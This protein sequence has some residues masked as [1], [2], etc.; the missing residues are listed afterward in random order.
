METVKFSI[1]EANRKFEQESKFNDKGKLI[2]DPAL[3]QAY[4]KKY[5]Y[6]TYDGNHYLWDGKKFVCNTEE[7]IKKVYFNRLN[8]NISRWYFKTNTKLYHV[9]NDVNK[10]LLLDDSINLCPGFK[11]KVPKKFNSFSK[12]TREAVELFLSY[13]KEVLADNDDTS[14]IYIMKWTANMCRG[15]K[16][17]TCLYFKSPEG[18]GKSTFTDFLIEFVLGPLIT[19]VLNNADVLIT[20][21]NSCLLGMLLVIFEELPTFNDAQW[22]VSSGKLKHMITGK[23][24][25]FRDLYIKQFISDNS[26]NYVLNTNVDALK[27]SNGRRIYICKVSTKRQGDH[28]YFQKLHEVCFNA[29]VGEAFFSYLFEL[30][31]E[32]FEAQKDMPESDKK[33]D[34]IVKLLPNTYEFLKMTYIKN[35]R[36]L[37]GKLSDVYDEYKE[38][39][40]LNELKHVL[41]KIDFNSRLKE[42]GI[43][44]YLSKGINKFKISYEELC[45]ICKKNNWIHQLDEIFMG[46]VETKENEPIKIDKSIQLECENKKLK[47]ELDELKQQM[48]LLNKIPTK[49]ECLLKEPEIVKV[50]EKPPKKKTKKTKEDKIIKKALE[51]LSI[52]WDKL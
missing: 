30:D 2:N 42:V 48:K 34:A 45:V 15:N 36:G 31:I 11:F 14:H 21:N 49:E 23:T 47:D 20:P 44:S 46:K 51:D 9:I 41:G 39:C 7:V 38:Y 19:L 17:S 32:G 13:M 50:E 43:E 22:S 52:A 28:K 1:E 12:E 5:F 10:P 35:K 37:Q 18:C 26:N 33:L 3:T 6:P 29:E 24:L 8:E 40:N 25:P 4:I 16:N 27:H